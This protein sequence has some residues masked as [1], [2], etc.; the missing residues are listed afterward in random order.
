MNPLTKTDVVNLASGACFF[1]AGGG[2]A[3]A[4]GQS[5]A[6]SL[7]ANAS[8]PFVT[9]DQAAG[10]AAHLT[11]VTVFIG[12]PASATEITAQS[13]IAAFDALN[14]WCQANYGKPIGYLVPGEMGAINATTACVVA[15]A[16]GLA[17]IDADGG[18][19]RSLPVLELASPNAFGVAANPAFVANNSTQL[20]EISG[21]SAKQT[22]DLVR[23]IISAPEFAE[24]SGSALWTMNNEQL[25]TALPSQ[26]T[27]TRSIT[28]GAVINSGATNIVEQIFAMLAQDFPVYQI[29]TGT[30]TAQTE[31]ESGGFDV[32]Q[33]VVTL[34]NAQVLTIVNQNE[35]LLMYDSAATAPI[36]LLPDSVNYLGPQGQAI[37]NVEIPQ[38]VNQQ[39]YVIGIQAE[40]WMQTN[41]IARAAEASTLAGVGYFG[42]YTP[43]QPGSPAPQAR[44]SAKAA[45]RVTA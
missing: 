24:F 8:I 21:S 13:V 45:P 44:L 18:G 40:E 16:R 28:Y 29:W 27:V 4:S 22:D 14:D 35:N 43:L 42:Q 15:Q 11:A 19:G 5:L 36:V 2:G 1:A 10:D 38:Y 9:V 3:L 31:E 12:A 30:L 41:P 23:G 7:P 17:V 33:T 6:G 34:G 37:S 39:I 26:G 25:Q 32:G 20:I